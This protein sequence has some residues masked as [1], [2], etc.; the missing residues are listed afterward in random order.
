MHT[1][2]NLSNMI[3]GT[4]DD[5]KI[6]SESRNILIAIGQLGKGSYER[7]CLMM[8]AELF[9]NNVSMFAYTSKCSSSAREP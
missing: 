1:N 3:L 6:V 4:D 9:S 8:D 5:L 2:K 7:L